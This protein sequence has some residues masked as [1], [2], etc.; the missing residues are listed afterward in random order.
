MKESTLSIIT[1]CRNEVSRIQRTIDSVIQQ[2]DSEFE[3]IVVDGAS[4]DGTLDLLQRYQPH[5][6]RLISEPDRGLYDAMNKGIGMAGGGFIL[7]LNAGDFLQNL[8][9]VR[10]FHKRASK[11]DIVVGDIHIVYPDGSEKYRKSAEQRLD[12]ELLYWRSFD[13]Q[14]TFIK[15]ALFEKFGSYD[16][17]FKILADWE[18]FARSVVSH[19]ASVEAWDHCVA[20]YTFDGISARLE[21]RQ[22]LYRERQ[23][24]RKMHYPA[25][26]RWRRDFNEAWGAMIH[27]IRQQIQQIRKS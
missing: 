17:S 20:V 10:A 8:E 1:I 5:I 18:F 14:G 2:S 19:E 26:Y 13:H 27:R 22:Q 25:R 21:N 23:R 7:F 11:A 12:K 4:T 16:L 9:V 3:W 24:I 15:R 6:F